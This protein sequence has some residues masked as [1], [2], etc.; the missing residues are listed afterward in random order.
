MTSH[1][2]EALP[3][4]CRTS[5]PRELSKSSWKPKTSKIDPAKK[6]QHPET[7]PGDNQGCSPLFSSGMRPQHVEGR[8]VFPATRSSF[9]LHLIINLFS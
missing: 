3:K 6:R 1:R 7:V 2:D 9:W 8:N 5:R 4:A